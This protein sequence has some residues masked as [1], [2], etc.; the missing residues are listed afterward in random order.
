MNL[1][2]VNVYRSKIQFEVYSVYNDKRNSALQNEIKIPISFSMGDKLDYIRK[3]MSMIIN[4]NKVKK[5]YLNIKDN[6]DVDTIKLEGTLEEVLS[7]C[8]VEI[9]N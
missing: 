6:L 3:F 4:Q 2:S 1:I 9:C 8:G 7:N 5:A